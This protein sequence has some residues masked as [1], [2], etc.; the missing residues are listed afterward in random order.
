M[1]SDGIKYRYYK[2]GTKHDNT[3]AEMYRHSMA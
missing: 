1:S 3:W 2:E